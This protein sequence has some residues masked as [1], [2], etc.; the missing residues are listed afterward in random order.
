MTTLLWIGSIR[1]STVGMVIVLLTTAIARRDRNALL[2]APAYF[3]GFESAWQGTNAVLAILGFGYAEADFG[4]ISSG[5]GWVLAA[6]FV[7]VRPSLPI[8]GL[9]AILWAVWLA[10]GFHSNAPHPSS[11]DWTA[12]VLNELA[13]TTWGLA[14]LV[15]IVRAKRAAGFPLR[16]ATH[17]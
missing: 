13:K 4:W 15:P 17:E 8:A 10:T 3:L 9:A 6:W 2:A 1:T 14:Y 11:I 5:I 16:P 12:E 7:G